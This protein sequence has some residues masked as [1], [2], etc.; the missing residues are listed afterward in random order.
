MVICII[1]MVLLLFL[2]RPRPL[3]LLSL[4]PWWSACVFV[5]ISTS[6]L[7]LIHL[8]LFISLFISSFISSSILSSFSEDTSCI[9]S[10]I[11]K[12]SC[13]QSHDS[14]SSIPRHLNLRSSMGVLLTASICIVMAREV[15]EEENNEM[16]RGRD[17]VSDIASNHRTWWE[18]VLGP[19]HIRRL[20]QVVSPW[21]RSTNLEITWKSTVHQLSSLKARFSR[22]SQQL[23]PQTIGP[24][25]VQLALS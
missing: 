17:H 6:L 8:S 4:H 2:S 19:P 23:R 24:P 3:V 20:H 1:L 10:L 13:S 12:R 9:A 22:K 25:L 7:L 15:E 21:R 14:S 18:N 16:S 5:L 11:Y